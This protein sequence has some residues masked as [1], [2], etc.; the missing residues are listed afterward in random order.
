MNKIALFTLLSITSI[1][2]FC[3]NPKPGSKSAKAAAQERIVNMVAAT[4]AIEAAKADRKESGKGPCS[5]DSK[6]TA[7]EKARSLYARKITR[8]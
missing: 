4:R 1:A 3:G 7:Y 8:K 2:I 5:G 6:R